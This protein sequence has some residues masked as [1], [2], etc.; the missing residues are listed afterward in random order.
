ML[1]GVVVLKPGE[2][3]AAQAGFQPGDIVREVNGEPIRS[4]AALA[5][6][7]R[8][9]RSWRLVIERGGRRISVTFGL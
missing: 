1:S 7:L 3:F 6:A 8:A 2:T 4:T 5:E 9:A